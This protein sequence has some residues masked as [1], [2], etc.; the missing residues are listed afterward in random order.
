MTNE[1]Y[2]RESLDRILIQVTKTNGRVNALEDDMED[3]TIV[4]NKLKDES[5]Y[6]KGIT[7][8]T[9]YALVALA[10]IAGYFIAHLIEKI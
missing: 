4:V 3:L 8:A 2:I 5:H 6:K 9:Y 10:T 7:K 1:E